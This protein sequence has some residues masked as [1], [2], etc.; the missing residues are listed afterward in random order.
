MP[1]GNCSQMNSL[2]ISRRYQSHAKTARAAKRTTLENRLEFRAVD[3]IAMTRTKLF[4]K[5]FHN[6]IP[7]HFLLRVLYS[8]GS[9]SVLIAVLHTRLAAF[10]INK[11]ERKGTEEIAAISCH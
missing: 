8:Y 10:T 5:H 2:G 3:F 11:K 9:I 1:A 6:F 4:Y 7:L